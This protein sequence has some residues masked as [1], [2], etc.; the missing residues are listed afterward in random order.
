MYNVTPLSGTF[1]LTAIVGGVISGTYIYSYDKTWGFTLALFFFLMFVASMISL[2]Y[3]ESPE[4][5]KK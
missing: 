3:A 4:D 1:L 2:T 5:I